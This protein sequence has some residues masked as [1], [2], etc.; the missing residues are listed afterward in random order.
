[1]GSNS[2][3]II[4]CAFE[5]MSEYFILILRH[6]LF[7][8]YIEMFMRQLLTVKHFLLAVIDVCMIYPRDLREG[9]N[10][11]FR[12]IITKVVGCDLIGISC[13]AVSF[14][15][16]IFAYTVQLDI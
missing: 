13:I 3:F 16:G 4:G 15:H 12:L 1:M 14:R 7:T 10:S 6:I 2:S 8:I 9:F 11:S 5:Q